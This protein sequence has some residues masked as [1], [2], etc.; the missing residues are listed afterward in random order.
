MKRAAWFLILAAMA[1]ALSAAPA[2]AVGQYTRSNS[3]MRIPMA[4]AYRHI[5][6]IMSFGE[7][8]VENGVEKEISVPEMLNPSDIFIDA[9]DNLY[10]ADS[11]NN[12]IV[13]TDPEGRVLKCYDKDSGY[14]FNRPC[15]IF[16]DRDG[17]LFVSDTDNNRIVHIGR[18][19]GIIEE[20]LKPDSNLI[21]ET[22]L[23]QPTKLAIGPTGYIYVTMYEKL[24]SIDAYNAFRGY[25]GQTKVRFSVVNLFVRW[26]AS[27]E[28]KAT[29]TRPVAPAVTGIFIDEDGMI[30]CTTKD[31]EYGEIKKFNLI[32]NN[33]Y[34][35]KAYGEIDWFSGYP[36][37]A[38]I[39]VDKAGIITVVE[40]NTGKIYQYDQSGNL[41]TVFGGLGASN[42]YFQKPS[43]IA[44]DSLGNI[45]VLDFAACMVQVFGPTDFINMVHEAIGLSEDA[46][47]REAMEIWRTIER[48]NR[49]YPLTNLGIAKALY[50]EGSY[51][52]AM[53]Y[54][55]KANDRAGYSDAYEKYRNQNTRRSFTLAVVLAAVCA[56]AF[57]VYVSLLKRASKSI[58]AKYFR[59]RRGSGDA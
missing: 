1:A 48:I 37:F 44:Q 59:Y 50:K 56:A 55:K 29:V 15:G 54:Y 24:I 3:G 2:Q 16:V 46:R 5:R 47:Y 7:V 43:G 19:G 42:G 20:F 36:S 49:N 31:H 39:T 9:D 52:D 57:I 13:M 21:D 33:I 4:D 26:F 6:N 8:Y 58:L 41:I 28:M 45:Y 51:Y 32:G 34:P 30:Y 23:F 53:A 38:G 40:E 22:Q 14:G 18:D 11:G 17:D 10:I 25:V 27:A 12:R 35:E